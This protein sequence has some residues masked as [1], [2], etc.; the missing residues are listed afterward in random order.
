[1]C[2]SLCVSMCV[3]G[4]EGWALSAGK[5]AGVLPRVPPPHSIHC[6]QSL[7]PPTTLI[8]IL[9]LY[10]AKSAINHLCQLSQVCR[11]VIRDHPPSTHTHTT[12]QHSI[13]YI[14]N[15]NHIIPQCHTI[16]LSISLSISISLYLCVLSQYM[17]ITLSPLINSH[18]TD[19][20]NRVTYTYTYTYIYTYTYTYTY[21]YPYIVGTML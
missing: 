21:T 14:N 19:I 2:V 6:I 3:W 12:G 16:Y 5:H 8:S 11:S 13:N 20:R 17:Y 7:P 15:P 18:T 1:M 10:T 9:H 4:G